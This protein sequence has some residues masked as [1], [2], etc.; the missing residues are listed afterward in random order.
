MEH[1][2]P[3]TRT[4]HLLQLSHDGQ[5]HDPGTPDAREDI[6]NWR[7]AGY[8]VGLMVNA[9]EMVIDGRGPA[10]ARAARVG[11]GMMSVLSV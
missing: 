9:S 3:I 11:S 4:N 2:I 6:A 10:L 7:E 1:L 5:E 8:S